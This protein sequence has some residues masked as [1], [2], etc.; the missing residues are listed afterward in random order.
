VVVNPTVP[1]GPGDRSFT[2]PTAML[3]LFLRKPPP[4]IL[5]FVMNLVDVSDV[6]KGIV[7]AAER[8]RIGE[9]YVLGGENI[10]VRDVVQ[11]VCALCGRRTRPLPLPGSAA[12]MAGMVAEWF[13]NHVSHRAPV[14]T[15]EGIRLAL[16]SIPLD[17]R[18]AQVDLGY[19][20]NGIGRALADTVAWL[21]QRDAPPIS[22]VDDD[23]HTFGGACNDAR[24][25]K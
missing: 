3:W 23:D 17:T 1:I 14:A 19:A 21:S 25:L 9:R 4:F 15:T 18:K 5:D 20:P 2:P 7:L 10:M 6:A 13:A 8:G 11:R 22:P 24:V 16:R 12:L